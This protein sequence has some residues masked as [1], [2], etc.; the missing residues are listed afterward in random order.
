[1]I[2]I[3]RKETE[4]ID[5]MLKRYKRR[6]RDVGILK[7]V[8]N[9]KSYRKKSVRRRNEILNAVYREANFSS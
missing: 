6:H 1:M 8:R 3:E 9:R 4:T 2:K 7:E 5:R